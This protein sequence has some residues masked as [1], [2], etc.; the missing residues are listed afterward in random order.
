VLDISN[1]ATVEVKDWEY[2][3]IKKENED[4]LTGTAISASN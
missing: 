1:Y 3:I 4:F 2:L